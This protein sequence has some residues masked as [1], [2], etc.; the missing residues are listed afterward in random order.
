MADEH[1]HDDPGVRPIPDPTTRTVEA[2]RR[3]IGAMT[4]VFDAK[5]QGVADVTQEQHKHIQER[6]KWSEDLRKEQKADTD[7]NVDAA[8]TALKEQISLLERN[9]TAGTAA[10]RRDIDA[11]RD[12]IN[13]VDN[14]IG[15]G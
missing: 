2:L 5:L 9:L 10:L 4:R 12:R 11:L 1:T 8:L 14:R 3:D 15:G 6:F 7:R 13:T